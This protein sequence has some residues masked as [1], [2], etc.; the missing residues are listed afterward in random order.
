MHKSGTPNFSARRSRSKA[1]PPELSSVLTDKLQEVCLTLQSAARQRLRRGLCLSI[2]QRGRWRD[3]PGFIMPKM[4][5]K[6]SCISHVAGAMGPPAKSAA[7]RG[8]SAT[9]GCC[10]AEEI[11]AKKRPLAESPLAKRRREVKTRFEAISL[12][13]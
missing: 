3:V 10:D 8:S 13:C 2:M 11:Q 4:P 12:A 9:D 6:S 7:K 5:Q 1:V